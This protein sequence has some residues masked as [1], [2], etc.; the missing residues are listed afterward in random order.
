LY[1]AY[2]PRRLFWGSDLTRL[3]CSYRVCVSLFTEEL[4]WLSAHDVEWI[5]GRALCEW[6]DWPIQTP[7]SKRR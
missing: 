7:E 1:D 3:P 2:G 5:M 4:K 6:L